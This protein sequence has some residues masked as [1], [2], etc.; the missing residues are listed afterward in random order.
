M[1]TRYPTVRMSAAH[2][3]ATGG[4]PVEPKTVIV[5]HVVTRDSDNRVSDT[6]AT[7]LSELVGS[8]EATVLREGMTW[9]GT[10]N[11]PGLSEP[12]TLEMD[13]AELTL[14]AGQVWVFFVAVDQ[15]VTV[16]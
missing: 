12:T 5:Q 7:P 15:R 9:H 3:P 10:W 16:E 1:E 11:R 13:G 2:D 4:D 14:A 8:G 6:V